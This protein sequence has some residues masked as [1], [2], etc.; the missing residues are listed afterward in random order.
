MHSLQLIEFCMIYRDHF[1]VS[2]GIIHGPVCGKGVG[3][4]RWVVQF[5]AHERLR[6]IHLIEFLM[7]HRDHVTVGGGI[8]QGSVRVKKSFAVGGM[9]SL[10]LMNGCIVYS[11]LSF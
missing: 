5:E 8:I 2:G 1:L 3:P 9:C 10:Q 4:M 6:S 11:S 7:I